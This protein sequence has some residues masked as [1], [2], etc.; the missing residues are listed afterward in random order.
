[1]LN[2]ASEIFSEGGAANLEVGDLI[3]FTQCFTGDSIQWDRF[4]GIVKQR[5]INKQAGQRTVSLNCLDYISVLT[6][7][8]IDK[9]VEG[10]KVAVTNEQLVPNY[11]PSPNDDL[12]QILNFANNNLATKPIPLI[13]IQDQN[14]TN[15]VDTQYDG[16]EIYYNVGQLKL[17]SSLNVRENYHVLSTYSYYTKGAYA[18]DVIEEIIKLTDGYS[19]F[20]FNESSAA[21]VVSNHLTTA[22]ETEE[23]TGETDDLVPIVLTETFVITT[24]LDGAVSLG[25]NS[26]T[27]DDATGFPTSGIASINGDSFTWSGKSTN[28]LTGIPGTDLG[29]HADGDYVEYSSGYSPGEVWRTKYNNIQTT[30]T[31]ADFTLPLGATFRYFDHRYGRLILTSAISLTKIVTCNTNYSFK[32]LQATGIELNQISFRA[33]EVDNRLAAVNKVRNYLAP[34]YIIRTQGD[35]NIWG[36]YLSQSSVADYTLQLT[37]G[38]TYLEDEDLFTRVR[39][40]G[41]NK[42]PTNIMFGDDIDYSADTEDEYT[43]NITKEELSYFGEEKSGVLSEWAQ[44]LLDEAELLG[45]PNTQATIEFVKE[46]YIDKDYGGQSATGKHIFGTV[47]SDDRGKIILDTITPIV[48]I[49]NV[50]IN[51]S[52]QRQISVPI[53]ITVKTQTITEGGG[54]SKSTS[55]H[56]YYYYT[57]VFPHAGLVPS[58]SIYLYDNQGLLRHTIAAYD[59]NVDYTSGV[60][61]IPGIEQND[62]NE[63]LATASY[64]VL[65]SSDSLEIIY[66]DVIFKINQNILPEPINVFVSATFE[67][68]AIAVGIRDISSIV[69]GRRD[70]QFQLEFFGEPVTGFHLATIDLGATYAIQAIDIS[71]GFFKPD[72]LRKFD[73]GFKMS[74]KYSLN[75]TDFYSISD[76]TENFEIVSGESESFEEDD[77]G[78]D[79]TTRYLK[80]NLEEVDKI[81]YGKGRYVVAINELSVYGDII[82]DSEAKLIPTTTLT[83]DVNPGDP[84]VSVDNTSK[85]TEPA[86]SETATAYLDKDATKPFTYTGLESGDTFTG[87]TVGGGI[88]A[89]IGDY[90]TQTIVGDTTVYDNDGLLPQLGDRLYKKILISDRNLYFSSELD[91]L[92][93]DYLEE[94]YKNHSKIRADILFAPYLK[95][96]ETVSVTDAYN[97]ISSVRYFIETI[98]DRGGNYSITLA[99]YPS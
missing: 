41:K 85:F 65:Y 63:I 89:S 46:K 43:G 48:Y 3:E 42:Q 6:N 69:D 64:H 77:L 44:A 94:F 51:N 66:D 39:M 12:A 1:M 76:K 55:V 54:K 18:E 5:S 24:T 60:W 50:P 20:L 93:K 68:W 7:L 32:T 73:I 52:I 59:P 19:G 49:N 87:C 33:R 95:I 74:M 86:L 78:M 34:N 26:V 27:L 56:T 80:F 72:D 10:T 82:I 75:G 25:A 28:T 17:G 23:G 92:A 4:Y 70:T 29:A 83:V 90:I 71:G 21:D 38:L 57:V 2:N 15:L 35:G 53:K 96:G 88:S 62:V 61:T 9:D 37:K 40:W 36:S 14:H 31:S 99:R 22:F 30:L 13:R 67:Y 98:E 11:L 79:F 97:N 84:T 47:I 91:D 8:S 58:E 16:F 45:Q 81:D